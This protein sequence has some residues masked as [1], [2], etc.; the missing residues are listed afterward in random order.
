MM[1]NKRRFFK[2]M[3]PE[4]TA[5]V[6]DL[7]TKLIGETIND[8]LLRAI[9]VGVV[10]AGSQYVQMDADESLIPVAVATPSPAP[11][12]TPALVAPAQPAPDPGP[13]QGNAAK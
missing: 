11:A 12:P 6:A 13:A 3:T 9:L 2:P 7:L 8:K 1:F 5:N 10:T 4:R